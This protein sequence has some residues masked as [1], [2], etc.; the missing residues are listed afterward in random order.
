M[1]IYLGAIV[2][3][4]TKIVQRFITK[5]TPGSIA[6]LFNTCTTNVYNY[7]NLLLFN[8]ITCITIGT[9]G[10]IPTYH[11]LTRVQLLVRNHVLIY[12]GFASMKC[13]EYSSKI[14]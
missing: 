10:K 2:S 9:I 7:S 14:N 4:K 3:N 1:N 6:L 13:G 8:N 12:K 11:Y 5:S